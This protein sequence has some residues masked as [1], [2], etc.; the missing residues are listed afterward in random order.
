MK[1]TVITL[2]VGFGIILA[3]AVE[4]TVHQ[5]THAKLLTRTAAVGIQS[6]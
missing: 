2:V 4:T 1:R 3:G 5:K 6:N